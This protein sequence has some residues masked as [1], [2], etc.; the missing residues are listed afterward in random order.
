MLKS[1]EFDLREINGNP[2]AKLDDDQVGLLIQNIQCTGGKMY[3]CGVDNS[4]LNEG[5][6]L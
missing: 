6:R 2:E 1:V 4:W 5:G 3:F